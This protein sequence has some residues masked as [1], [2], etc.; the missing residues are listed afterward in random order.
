MDV[1]HEES[2]R[3]ERREGLLRCSDDWDSDAL[4]S[5]LFDGEGDARTDE[6]STGTEEREVSLD[7]HLGIVG[8]AD[9]EIE[10]PLVRRKDVV[11]S[12]V[13][14]DEARRSHLLGVAAL[15]LGVRDGSDV[16]SQGLCEEKSK[17]SLLSS[18]Q[19]QAWRMAESRTYK[20]SDT[21]D[22][23]V[24]G[25]RSGTVLGERRVDRDSSAQHGGRERRV[26][27]VGNLHHK[28]SRCP[29]VVGVSTVRL[30]ALSVALL[31]DAVVGTNHAVVAVALA[32]V[33]ALSALEARVGLGSNTDE[34]S[35]LDVRDGRSNADCGS[36]ELVSDDAGVVGGAPPG[37][38]GVQVRCTDS[39]VEDLD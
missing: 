10:R 15:G 28:V 26:Q 11:S 4:V 13:R 22:S 7:G 9:D 27:A 25:R 39:R 35:H 29:V 3:R 24:L 20:T 33:L 5:S 16:G 8:R 30:I 14:G 37:G 32:L 21:D 1:V 17:V 2:E 38:H 34:V 23:N 6:V 12:A 18:C 31:V 19:Y 36:N